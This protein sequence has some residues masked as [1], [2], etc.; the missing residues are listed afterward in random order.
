MKLDINQSNDSKVELLTNQDLPSW[1]HTNECYYPVT[2][3]TKIPDDVKDRYK[4]SSYIVDPNKYGWNR[5]IRII[6]IIKRFTKCCLD[7]TKIDLPSSSEQLSDKFIYLTDNELND[8]ANYYFRKATLEIKHFLKKE[9]YMSISQGKDTILYY[10]GRILP[11]QQITAV[12]DKTNAMKDLS[13]ISF[14]V[15]L[16]EKHSPIAYSIINEV[17]WNNKTVRHSGVET[18]LRYTMQY[19]YI[20]EGR[21]LV[22]KF[23]KS[24]ERCKYL[25]KETIEVSMGA[26]S[27]YNLKIAPCFYTCQVDLA[28]PFKPYSAHHKRTVIKMWFAVFCCTATSTVCIK[29]MED[30]S[31]DAF[32]Q[33]FIRLSCEVGYPK[34]L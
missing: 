2:T 6:A 24:C 12:H 16:V 31:S 34:R 9:S 7:K 17:H 20:I 14:F 25:R 32:V 3:Q 4:F 30:Y 15:P 5:S 27:D 26:V 21:E 19:C 10:V 33:A 28:G 1:C 13:N 22:R 18:I 11:N 23:A 8:A 29:V